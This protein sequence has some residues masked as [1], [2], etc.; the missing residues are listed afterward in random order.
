MWSLLVTL[1]KC[2]N[3]QFFI[4]L[5]QNIHV[6]L[7]YHL[8]DAGKLPGDIDTW[9]V[10][11]PLQR[12]VTVLMHCFL[13]CGLGLPDFFMSFMFNIFRT[14]DFT[15][16]GFMKNMHGGQNILKKYSVCSTSAFDCPWAAAVFHRGS[17]Q[18]KVD[19]EKFVTIPSHNIAQTLL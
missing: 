13:A 19:W 15:V 17:Q 6:H 16:W 5:P 10:W 3:V 1:H 18:N 7:I 11:Y 4:Y 14:F 8:C 9:W 2:P 12:F